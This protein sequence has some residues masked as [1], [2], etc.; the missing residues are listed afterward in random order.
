MS[1]DTCIPIL[2]LC[3][4]RSVIRR[5]ARIGTPFSPLACLPTWPPGIHAEQKV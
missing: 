3:P 4:A 1:L 2:A 5:D